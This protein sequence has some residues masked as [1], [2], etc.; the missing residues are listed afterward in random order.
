VPY[1][2][3][4]GPEGTVRWQGALRDLPTKELEAALRQAK[5]FGLPR[6]HDVHE[7]TVK[8]YGKGKLFEAACDAMFT[9]EFSKDYFK[10]N[11]RRIQLITEDAEYIK[12]R[13]EGYRAY[14][15][16]LVE[17]GRARGDPEQVLYA[18]EQIRLCFGGEHFRAKEYGIRA[19]D[20]KRAAEERDEAKKDPLVDRSVRATRSYDALVGKQETTRL[21]ADAKA[22]FARRFEDFQREWGGTYAAKR[23]ARRAKW[24]AAQPEE[25]P[26]GPPAK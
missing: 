20:D 3:L 11:E 8:L 23:A 17:E 22:Q 24:L 10:G 2:Y 21:T 1:A 7:K 19:G 4:I 12:D 9:V 14:W 13:A 16:Q 6:L 25:A 18:L 5:P 26:K 15:W